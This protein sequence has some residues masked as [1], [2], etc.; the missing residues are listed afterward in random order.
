MMN[1]KSWTTFRYYRPIIR[2]ITN[3]SK[4]T[5]IGIAFKSTNITTLH[6]AKNI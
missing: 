6:T 4:H 2:K 3:V 5:N 1:N